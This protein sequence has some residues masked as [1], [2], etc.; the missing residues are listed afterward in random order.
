MKFQNGG[1]SQRYCREPTLVIS[2]AACFSGKCFLILESRSEY[3]GQY[4]LNNGSP[5]QKFPISSPEIF[6]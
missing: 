1:T 4:L 6:K 2:F 3:I 5:L